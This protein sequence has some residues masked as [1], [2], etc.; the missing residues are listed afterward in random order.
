MAAGRDG[1]EQIGLLQEEQQARPIE[2]SSSQAI[3]LRQQLGL[4]LVREKR[5]DCATKL[6]HW[7]VLLGGNSFPVVCQYGDLCQLSAHSAALGEDTTLYL[8]CISN[9]PRGQ[10]GAEG[11]AFSF[12]CAGWPNKTIHQVSV[13]RVVLTTS[14]SMSLA[15][16]R[17]VG[18]TAGPAASGSTQQRPQCRSPPAH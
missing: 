18:K 9:A 10:Q 2:T 3:G 8:L 12:T 11:L 4:S 6:G 7:S 17:S 14:K 13:C 15:S 5:N 1:Q 16:K